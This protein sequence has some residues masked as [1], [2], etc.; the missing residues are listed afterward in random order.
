MALHRRYPIAG[1]VT[2]LLSGML[3]AVSPAGAAPADLPGQLILEGGSFDP[4]PGVIGLWTATPGGAD[5]TRFMPLGSG[6]EFS[7]AARP[8]W[9]P[10]EQLMAFE[11]RTPGGSTPDIWVTN[12]NGTDPVK[13]TDFAGYDEAPT[14]SPDGSTIAFIRHDSDNGFVPGIW[15]MD[16]DGGN[17][18]LLVE[19]PGTQPWPQGLDW[20]P[21]AGTLVT[22]S[23]LEAY[24]IDVDDPEPQLL[25][26]SPGSALDLPRWSPD[27]ETLAATVEVTGLNYDTFLI[28]PDDGSAVNLTDTPGQAEFN[29]AWSPDGTAMAW[30][31]WDGPFVHTGVWVHE[32]GPDTTTQVIPIDPNAESYSVRG[33]LA[34]PIA[35]PTDPDEV[36]TEVD[37]GETVDTDP[38]GDGA[39]A[40]DPVETA[41]TSPNAG[42][43]T[44]D[45]RPLSASPPPNYEFL[46][47]E[48]AIS[49]PAASAADPLV[50]VFRVD[51]SLLPA[52][53]GPGDIVPFRTG[54]AVPACTGA[55]GTASPDPCLAST[56][57]ESDG[58]VSL[59]VL[60]SAASL[61]NFGVSTVPPDTTP[62][63]IS[64][65]APRQDASYGRDQAV[66]VDYA[67][68]DTGSGVA[69]CEGTRSDGALLNTAN[70]GSVS[71]RVDAAD[72]AGNTA[73]R[74]VTYRVVSRRAVSPTLTCVVRGSGGSWT[75]RFGY[76]NQN[77]FPVSLPV[78]T[79]NGFTT[80][81][82]DRGQPTYFAPGTVNNVVQVSFR[83]TVAWRVDGTTVT[84]RTSSRRC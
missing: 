79:R 43:V 37:P 32:F 22:V 26:T 1:A 9:S 64:L 47:Q 57:L 52:D 42:T 59:T 2:A 74:S 67:C 50:L 25:Y 15:L 23:G 84:A 29:L 3:L 38:E 16:A 12:A 66:T 36:D 11:G 83:T 6:E 62:P 33:W 71:F 39:T 13:L 76:R 24:T 73:S 19:W 28:D 70:L 10:D 20:H 60:T 46:G 18:R 8:D 44:V 7:G 21:S 45:E 58:D 49:A 35:P 31:Q 41:V 68:S 75:A 54:T 72:A 5:L 27:G 63:T 55:A 56:V 48:V 81:P 69:S 4:P 30:N 65:T 80:E 78:G 61:W 40:D 17:E 14:W 53:A 34:E 51:A 82:V 77:S